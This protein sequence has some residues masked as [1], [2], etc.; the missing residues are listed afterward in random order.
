MT[1]QVFISHSAKSAEHEQIL[2]RLRKDLEK[3]GLDPWL[4]RERLKAGVIWNEAISEALITCHAAIILF[5]KMALESDFVK[6]EVSNLLNRKRSQK[7]FGFFPVTIDGLQPDDIDKKFYGAIKLADVQIE[8]LADA[9]EDIIN[10]LKQL[11]PVHSNP[12]NVIEGMLLGTF[13]GIEPV[14]LRNSASELGFEIN[15]APAMGW[16]DNSEKRAVAL[17]FLR[18]LLAQSMAG[19]IRMLRNIEVPLSK[20]T[21]MKEILAEVAPWWVDDG[22]AEALCGV[23]K[24]GPGERI[25]LMNA[26]YGDWTCR[27]FL[28]RAHP[29]QKAGVVGVAPDDRGSGQASSAAG[30]TS[31]SDN[32][33]GS[34][35]PAGRRVAPDLVIQTRRALCRHLNISETDNDAQTDKLIDS[36]LEQEEYLGTPSIQVVQLNP[37]NLPAARKIADHFKRLT[38]VAMTGEKLPKP[39]PDDLEGIATVISPELKHDDPVAPDDEELAFHN[40]EF[41]HRWYAV[42]CPE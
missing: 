17:A 9:Q 31:A 15:A 35:V 29:A 21:S 20:I 18:F 7:S 39:L 40:E 2:D 37:R 28:S 19:Q 6:Y 13:R 8:K 4:D 12:T 27:M 14:V 38:V 25:A 22:A 24:K 5:S 16:D 41:A 36:R 1:T 42:G 33:M 11:D 3:A 10:K 23:S 30:A 32:V 34:I 26:A